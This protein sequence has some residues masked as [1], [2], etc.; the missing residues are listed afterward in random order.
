MLNVKSNKIYIDYLDYSVSRP[1]NAQHM[2]T[3][4]RFD[5]LLFPEE[6][7]CLS[8]PACVKLDST[9][10]ALVCLTQFWD[11]GKIQLVL[12]RKHSGNPW[13]YFNKR[14][15]LLEKTF[16]EEDLLTHFEYSA[17][18]SEHTKFFYNT[19]V[20]EVLAPQYDIYI[21]KVFDTDELFRRSIIEQTN[22]RINDICAKLPV[23]NAIHTG[24]ILNDLTCIAEDRRSLFQR[25]AVNQQLQKEF[26]AYPY[27]IQIVN[28]M[29]DIGFSYANSM[30][31]YA[32]PLSQITNRLTARQFIP[33]LA[34]ADYELYD[35]ICK[36]DWSNLYFLS[37]ERVWLNFIDHLN[38]LLVLYQ[39]KQPSKK[40]VFSTGKFSCSITGSRLIEKLYDAAIDALKKEL[41]LNGANPMDIINL[42]KYSDKLLEYVINTRTEY[43]GIIRKT[44]ELLK[45]LKGVI[46]S[47]DRK[48]QGATKILQE[49]GFYI[50]I[51]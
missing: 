32:A 1:V 37:T 43:W 41:L 38:R 18:T 26:H 2:I 49:D 19:Y 28:H 29:L 7:K 36:M 21:G 8:V 3:R 51:I 42:Q 45:S 48:Y 39:R 50:N 47:L 40:E 6:T 24:K 5:L 16:G 23:Q 31:S 30:S 11:N 20:K 12:D 25:S 10:K 17:Y 14:K 34:Y 22:R 9:T 4:L 44:D 13:N 27:E 35:M 15:K 33:M 46:L